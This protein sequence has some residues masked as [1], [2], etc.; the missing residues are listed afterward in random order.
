MWFLFCLLCFL[1]HRYVAV[2]A[3]NMK[4]VDHQVT[5]LLCQGKLPNRRLQGCLFLSLSFPGFPMETLLQEQIGD[6]FII[7][8]S[9]VSGDLIADA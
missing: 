2:K 7:Y 9:K 6:S 3:D 1:Y 8:E 4:H 5:L